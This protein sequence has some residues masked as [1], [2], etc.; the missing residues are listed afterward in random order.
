MKVQDSVVVRFA[1]SDP[2][3]SERTSVAMPA[4][5]CR[6]T[7]TQMR[8]VPWSTTKPIDVWIRCCE[9]VAKCPRSL[10]L[11]ALENESLATPPRM[12]DGRACLSRRA[13]RS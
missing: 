6:T 12:P 2:P 10:M 7:R 11:L 8:S 5:S 9:N 4:P 1:K 13:N 3:R